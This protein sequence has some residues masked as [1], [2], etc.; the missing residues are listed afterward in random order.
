MKVLLI[1]LINYKIKFIIAFF[2]LNSLL[3]FNSVLLDF[4]SH[5]NADSLWPL[6]SKGAKGGG[7]IDQILYLNLLEAY[8]K[9]SLV[10]PIENYSTLSLASVKLSPEEE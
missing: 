9:Y 5:A 7:K 2:Y 3:F 6:L 10:F 8:A 1:Y 4:I